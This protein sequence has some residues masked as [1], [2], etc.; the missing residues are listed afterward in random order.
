MTGL[1]AQVEGAAI[2]GLGLSLAP[3]SVFP[4]VGETGPS[5]LPVRSAGHTFMLNGVRGF[6]LGLVHALAGEKKGRDYGGALSWH[7]ARGER[8]QQPGY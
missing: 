8:Q 7:H 2:E 4:T 3:F 5:G 1:L 6:A